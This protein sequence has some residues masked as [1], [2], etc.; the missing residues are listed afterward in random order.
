MSAAATSPGSMDNSGIQRAEAT[1]SMQI[2]DQILAVL[3]SQKIAITTFAYGI[4]VILVGTLAQ[5]EKDIWQ[6]V[7]E[8]FR[9][10]IMWVDINLF[11]PESFFPNWKRLDVPLIPMPGGMVVGVTMIANIVFA[12]LRWILQLKTKPLQLFGGLVLLAVGWL[13]TVLIILNGHNRGGFQAQPPFTWEQFW[14]G[15][16]LTVLGS[17]VLGFFAFIWYVVQPLVKVVREQQLTYFRLAVAT[18]FAVALAAYSIF[19]WFILMRMEYPGSEMLRIMWQLAQGTIAGGILLWGSVLVF[20]KRGGVVL[21]HQ[22]L[23]LLMLNE[24]IVAR[25]A[26]E[27]Q[28]RLIEGETKNYL[29]DMR[30]T[31]LALIDRSNP[32]VDTHTVIPGVILQANARNNAEL[33]KANKAPQPIPDPDNKLPVKVTV[34]RYLRNAEIEPLKKGAENI[35][36]TGIGLKQTAREVPAARGTD[37]DSSVDLAATYVKFTDKK[38]GNDLGTYLLAQ[39]ISEFSPLSALDEVKTGDK[40]YLV[41]LRFQRQYVPFTV[42]LTDVKRN[43]YLGTNKPR[44]YSSDIVLKD[45]SNGVNTAV[46]IKMNDPLRYS[47]LTFYQSGYT[48]LGDGLEMTSLAVVKNTGWLIPYVALMIITVG[49]LYHF[50]LTLIRFL[51]RRDSEELTSHNIVLV[52][53]TPELVSTAKA[54]SKRKAAPLLTSQSS[55]SS[56]FLH[57]SIAIAIA[58]LAWIATA[59]S[60]MRTPP[61]R[62]DRLDWESFG[63]IPVASGGRIMPIDTVARNALLQLRQRETA[64]TQEGKTIPATQWLLDVMTRSPNAITHRV[65]KIDNPDIKKIFNLEE[66]QGHLYSVED[67]LPNLK[68]FENQ[69]AVAREKREKKEE[70]SLLQ[71]RLLVVEGQMTQYMLLFRAFGFPDLPPFPE[72][73]DSQD[74]ARQK[75]LHIKLAMEESAEALKRGNPPLMIP[76]SDPATAAKRPWITLNEALTIW[77]IETELQ[78]TPGDAVTDAFVKVMS[79]YRKYADAADTLKTAQEKKEPADKIQK[80]ESEL[81]ATVAPFNTAVERYLGQIERLQPQGYSAEKIQLETWMNRVSPFYLCMVL[82]G[83]AFVV[84]LVGWLLPSRSVNWAA[85]TLIVLTFGLHTA[86]LWFRIQ[87]SG[88][89]PVTN[90][91]MAG[92]VEMIY[93]VGLGNLVASISGF[94][95][96]II[97]YFLSMSGDTIGVMEAVLDTQFWLSTHVVCVTLGYTAT[98]VAGL[99]GVM[100]VVFGLTTRRL[101]STTRRNLGRMIYGITCFAIFF[102]F[103]G[104]VLGGLWADDSW[105]RFWGWDPKENGALIIVLWNALI[106]HARWDKVVTERGMALLAIGGN[107]VT[108]WSWFGVNELGIGLHSYGFTDGVLLA[109]GLFVLSQ[110]LLI[111]VGL[112]PLKYWW[113]VSAETPQSPNLAS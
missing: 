96:L 65:F 86:S 35:A 70:L 44:N 13:I 67:L 6:V 66:R 97:A 17:W 41:A 107:I 58:T 49:M 111:A 85:F 64:K 2:L 12:H 25:Y 112:I 106:L 95:S 47:G 92:I 90:L 93:R 76:V 110:L 43:D 20:Q 109:L 50:L 10:V 37:T 84:T 16:Q 46:H 100:F 99:L 38:T 31:E 72:P 54:S 45:P 9:S 36:T 102:S 52:D 23:L 39:I 108:S 61:Q 1:S 63:C 89:P 40:P 57:Y 5:T 4:F 60:S 80:L 14:M 18:V 8:Y 103:F 101:D 26:V 11:F 32:E 78:Q 74:V 88:R 15:F 22:G 51:R 33:L 53:R 113:S 73:G 24:L 28:M 30:A 82:N 55:T 83:L 71:R 29:S 75:L 68:E 19:T 87:I 98:Y 105:G 3:G 21:L 79:A 42:H 56:T 94:A 77:L 59:Y 48:P 104:T 34:L 7:P 69:V 81:Q 27:Y 62:P 91:L